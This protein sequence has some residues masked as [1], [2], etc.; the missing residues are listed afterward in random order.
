VTGMLFHELFGS[1]SPHAPNLP[2]LAA[3][4]AETIV[5][6]LAPDA[7]GNPPDFQP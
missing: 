3:Q 4:H 7:P 6:G 5:R 2:T 1:A